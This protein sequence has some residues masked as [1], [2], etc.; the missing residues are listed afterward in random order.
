MGFPC[1][2]LLLNEVLS[3]LSVGRFIAS[4]PAI[5]T[6][7]AVPSEVIDDA[8]L[9]LL[10]GLGLAHRTGFRAF[11]GLGAVFGDKLLVEL[12]DGEK[13]EEMRFFTQTHKD[14]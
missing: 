2:Q 4:P 6:F 14:G 3:Q 12:E 11:A 7:E 5:R 10:A 9:I 8:D 1:E 13:D